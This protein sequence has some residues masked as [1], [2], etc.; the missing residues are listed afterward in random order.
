MNGNEIPC[1]N[2]GQDAECRIGISWPS[3]RFK[4]KEN[5]VRDLLTDLTWTQNAN[6]NEFPLSWDEAFKQIKAW[7]NEAFHGYTDWRLPNRRELRSLMSYQAQKPSLP[8]KHP[9][10]NIFL[11]WYWTSTSAAINPAYAWY[12]HLEGARMFYGKKDQYCLVWPVRG[13]GNGLLPQSGQKKCYDKYGYEMTCQNSSQ[14]G[15][16]RLGKNWPEPRFKANGNIAKD[17]LTGL[18]WSI[19][20]DIT[21]EPVEWEQALETI[22]RLND[23]KWEGINNWRLPNINELESLVDCSTHSPA[24]PVNNLFRNV[25]DGYWSSTTSYFELD[26]AWVLYMVKGA[27]GVGY[28]PGKTFFV[29]PV[30]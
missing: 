27:C 4:R 15:E 20:A 3:P 21:E 11:N 22:K 25:R 10:S 14:D 5:I 29:W 26:W 17:R 28:K 1:D 9:F 12:I 18:N 30:H 16:Y 19:N 6:P 2:S 13:K 8:K 7:N 23:K 24:L